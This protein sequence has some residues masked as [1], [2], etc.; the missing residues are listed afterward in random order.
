DYLRNL[1][2]RNE[3]ANKTAH[4]RWAVLKRKTRV[5]RPDGAILNRKLRP[6][7]E[8]VWGGNFEDLKDP[9]RGIRALR[10]RTLATLADRHTQ[11]S[12]SLL[13]RT[14]PSAHWPA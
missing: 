8:A 3:R 4:Q 10:I 12:F 6:S 11:I 1:V 7:N 14:L 13:T 2:E 5:W 9:E